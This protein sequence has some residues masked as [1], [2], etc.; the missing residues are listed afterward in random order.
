MN[1]A[2]QITPNAIR[3]INKVYKHKSDKSESEIFFEVYIMII[4][5]KKNIDVIVFENKESLWNI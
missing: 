2:T 1:R 4:N 5:T 3:F